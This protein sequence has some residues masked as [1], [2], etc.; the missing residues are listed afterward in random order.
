MPTVHEAIDAAIGEATAARKRVSKI[1]TNQVRGVDEIATL[2]AT[3]QTWFHTHRPVVTIGAPNVDL[4]AVDE[5]F[6]TVLDAT[7]KYAA[8]TTYLN[9]LKDAK[10]A[11]IAVRATALVAPAAAAGADTDD[12]APDFSPLAGNQQMRDILTRRWNECAK[13]VKADAHLAAIVMMGGLLEALFV[14]RITSSAKSIIRLPTSVW[15]RRWAHND[16]ADIDIAWLLDRKCDGAA[17]GIRSDR[18]PS[19]LAHGLLSA[20]M[21]NGGSEI[22]FHHA[23][24]NDSDANL[25]VLLAQ[26]LGNGNHGMLGGAIDG[27]SWI[28]QMASDRGDIHDVPEALLLHD[29]QYR[30]DAVQDA[31]NVDVDH[32]I[33]FIY[34]E[35]IERRQRHNTCIVHQHVNLAEFLMRKADKGREVL[36]LGYVE[37]AETRGAAIC[38]DVLGELLQPPGPA[39]AEYD[40]GASPGQLAGGCFTNA[41]RGA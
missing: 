24:G 37:R 10:T 13:C 40:P 2:K 22:G 11:L 9:A 14:A 26:A 36:G 18:D 30:R 8:K 12:L 4:V 27:G 29:R 1:R 31:A 16:F 41:A 15:A 34:L 23:R 3:A 38:I 25:R 32:L 7:A 28:N 35:R 6:T 5:C 33:P 39:G 17:D 21:R 20:R 19:K